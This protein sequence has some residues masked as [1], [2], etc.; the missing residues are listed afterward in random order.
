MNLA[1]VSDAL[2]AA[3]QSGGVRG[4]G[5][6]MTLGLFH[7]TV[8]KGADRD[9][10]GHSTA[11]VFGSVTIDLSDGEWPSGEIHFHV[12]SVF[13]G[14]EVF[15]PAGV[16]LRITG[17]SLFSR[18]KVRGL[19]TGTGIFSGHEYVSPGYAKA[20]RRLHLD[21]TSFFSG[22]QLKS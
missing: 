2:A 9:L 12:Y 16:G 8:L 22:V 17:I 6:G 21:L 5:R 7:S 20:T 1:Q 18:V 3:D 19:Q 14:V 10:D 11:S 15:V 13:G 4:A